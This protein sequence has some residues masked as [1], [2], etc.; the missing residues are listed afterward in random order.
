MKLNKEVYDK[1]GETIKAIINENNRKSYQGFHYALE[2]EDDGEGNHLFIEG[3]MNIIIY[4][5]KKECGEYCGPYGGEI[6]NVVP[7]WWDMNV[8]KWDDE[9]EEWDNNIECDIEWSE[10]KERLI[11]E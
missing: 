9:S 1:I 11:E 5:S 2:I 3:F 6:I 4:F 10:I 8:A 7:I